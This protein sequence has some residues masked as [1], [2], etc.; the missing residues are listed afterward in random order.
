MLYTVVKMTIRINKLIHWWI[1]DVLSDLVDENTVSHCYCFSEFWVLL[2]LVPSLRLTLSANAC[3]TVVIPGSDAAFQLCEPTKGGK[4]FLAGSINVADSNLLVLS[5]DYDTVSQWVCFSSPHCLP[6]SI[7]QLAL[8]VSFW[9]YSKGP[10]LLQWM[11]NKTIDVERKL[12]RL[13]QRLILLI[14]STPISDSSRS[15]SAL[16]TMCCQR[17]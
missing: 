14:A 6:L 8:L 4:F 16:Y 17:G 9:F 2:Q 10:Y 3:D 11:N 7:N 12:S 15:H 13:L 1:D 5:S